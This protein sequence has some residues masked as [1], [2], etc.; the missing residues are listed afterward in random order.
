MSEFNEQVLVFRWVEY[1]SR[2]YP[3]LKYL[4]SNLN[5]VRLPIGLAVKCKA[6]GLKKGVPD[7]TLDYNNGNYTGLHIEL[8]IKG[9]RVSPEQ[10]D[11]LAFLEKQGRKAVVCYGHK[12]T[13]KV[14]EEYLN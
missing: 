4:Y 2:K 3:Q 5:G 1:N 12:E 11:F 10:K 9:G 13:I 14:I 6:S 7:L 8:K